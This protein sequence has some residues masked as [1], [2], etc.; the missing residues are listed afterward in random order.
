MNRL[1]FIAVLALVVAFAGITQA[2]SIIWVGENR[3]VDGA[4]ENSDQGFIDLLEGAGY[5]VI[6]NRVIGD[7]ADDSYWKSL[8]DTKI[9]E[10]NA[11]GLVII[12]RATGSGNYDDNSGAERTQWNSITAPMISMAPHLMRSGGKWRWLNSSSISTL[13]ADLMTVINPGNPVIDGLAIDITNSRGDFVNVTDAG[14][15]DVL[16]I[17]SSDG[18][19]WMAFWA[20]GTEFYDGAEQFAGGDRLWLNA[21]G[22]GDDGDEDGFYNLTA[23]GEALYLNAVSNMFVPEPATMILLGLGGLLIRKRR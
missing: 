18:N 10:L 9:G 3:M 8:D 6:D 19:V 14:N 11:A 1:K 13:D 15:G 20:A 17:R 4:T 21:G 12:S 7:E 16:G 22:K 2:A 23:T 5:D